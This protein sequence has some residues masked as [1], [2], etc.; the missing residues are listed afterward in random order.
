LIGQELH[1][2]WLHPLPVEPNTN[3]SSDFI[4]LQSFSVSLSTPPI[5]GRLSDL[6][7]RCLLI[8]NG[9]SAFPPTFIE[10][11]CTLALAG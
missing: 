2:L 5:N 6:S 7:S 11:R 9:I 4:A 3:D 10:I 1:L 8:I